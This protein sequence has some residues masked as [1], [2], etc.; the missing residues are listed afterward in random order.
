MVHNLIFF[1]YL[2]FATKMHPNSVRKAADFGLSKA[3]GFQFFVVLKLGEVHFFFHDQYT[4]QEPKDEK[5][6]P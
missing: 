6:R 2:R 1:S 3:F 4:G 5:V